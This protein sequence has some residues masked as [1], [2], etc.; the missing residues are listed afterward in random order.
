MYLQ[1]ASQLAPDITQF[2]TQ[3]DPNDIEEELFALPQ[4]DYNLLRPETV[5]SLMILYRVT[6]DEIYREYGRIIMNAFEKQSKVS[7]L[8]NFQLGFSAIAVAPLTFFS[9]TG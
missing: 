7:D 2:I 5:E 3:V 4:Q 1:S 9:A 6:G 8:K